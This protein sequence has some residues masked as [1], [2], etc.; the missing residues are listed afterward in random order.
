MSATAE[1]AALSETRRIIDFL[2]LDGLLVRDRV[3][4]ASQ[5][6]RGLPAATADAVRETLG[7]KAFFQILPE[8]TYRR[9]KRQ[10]KPLTRETSE[11]LYEFGRVYELALRLYKGD[12]ART[13][14]F[15]GRAHAMLG[16]ES[17][18]ALATS[19]SAGADAVIDLLNRADAG[20]AA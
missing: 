14:G 11:K 3:A 8:A 1:P 17:P 19:S 16:G 5:V 9:V 4:L 12:R 20:F 13:M 15:L 7:P 2:G 10:A 6:A 18:I